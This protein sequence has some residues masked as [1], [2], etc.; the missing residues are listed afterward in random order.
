MEK[1]KNEKTADGRTSNRKEK[2]FIGDEKKVRRQTHKKKHREKYSHMK[3]KTEGKRKRQKN[4][5]S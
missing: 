2:K 1:I 4:E 5:N 3:Q